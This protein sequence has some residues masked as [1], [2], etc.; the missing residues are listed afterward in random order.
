MPDKRLL[1]L[2]ALAVVVAVAFMTVGLRGNIGFA[3]ELRAVRLVTL[4]QVGVAIAISTVVFQTVTA[5][6]VLT[7]QIMGL[8]ALY[9]FGQMALVLTLGSVGYVALD[10][11]LKFAGEA[12][13]MMVMALVLFLPMLRRRFDI[14]LLLLTGVVLG[15]LFRSLAMLIARLIDPNEFAVVQGWSFADFNTVRP[16]L[17]VVGLA[18]T[19]IAAV[20]IWR[21]RRLLD[22]VALGADSATGLGVDWTK[23]LAGLLLLVAALVAVSTALVGPVTFFGLLVV[24][25]A[26]RIVNSRRHHLLLPAAMLT[27]VVVLLGAQM[28]LQHVLGGAATLGVV[29]EFVGGLVF[30]VM[31]ITTSKR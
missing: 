19:T 4:V 16:D 9:L 15:V 2:A 27:A 14:G 12:G 24:A 3:L 18:V 10:P 21:L 30:L 22:I 5:N 25:L 17:V 23:A 28:L 26:E 11:R 13:L 31:L 8:D 20:I 1:I 6:R 7:P 29:I